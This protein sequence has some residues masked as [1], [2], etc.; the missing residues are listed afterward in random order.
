MKTLT[1]DD[2]MPANARKLWKAAEAAGWQVWATSATGSPVD[3]AGNVKHVTVRVPLV[4][5]QTGRPLL[6][7]SGKQRHEVLATDQV[8]VVSSVAVRLR[9]DDVRLVAVWADG[10]FDVGLRQ[11]PLAKLTS[12][13]LV[14]LVTA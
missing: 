8:Q 2:E 3:D 13:E 1:L 12:R 10:S 4:D 11:R 6:T 9:K 14:A 7:D 5:T